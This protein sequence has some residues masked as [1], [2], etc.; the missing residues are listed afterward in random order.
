MAPTIVHFEIPADNIERANKFYTDL[1]GWKMEKMPG[2]ME[3]WMFATSA[4]SKGEQT[5]SG[6]VIERKMS[7]EP[8]TIYI[9]VNS[10]NDYA[11]K[12]EELGG[13]IIKPKTEGTGYAWFAVCMDTENNI[14][15]LW[16][17]TNT[18]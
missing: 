5:M 4:N 15:A 11:K 8:I 2:P 13:K 17:A 3:Y 12:V 10:V 7:S 18:G 1:F 14:F 6:G 16:E 9:G